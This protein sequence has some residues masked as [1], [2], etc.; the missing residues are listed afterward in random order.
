MSQKLSRRALR[1][2]LFK[3]LFACEFYP[4][5]EMQEQL[6]IYLEQQ[7][8]SDKDDQRYLS[9]KLAGILDKL[10][11]IDSLLNATARKW[12]TSRMNKPDL[13]ILR[14][15]VYEA[16]YDDSIPEGVAINEA[17]ELAKLYSSDEAASF[18]NGILAT[19]VR[20]REEE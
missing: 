11:E 5:E 6:A 1:E 13:S 15:A 18:I 4:E 2:H 17:V 9:E 14:L 19:V 8:I 12:K 10:P 7:D 16:K 20:G 3:L